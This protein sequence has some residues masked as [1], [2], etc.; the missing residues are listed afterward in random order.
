VYIATHGRLLVDSVA[1]YFIAVNV[2]V[3]DIAVNCSSQ[4]ST[5]E[6]LAEI[7]REDVNDACCN[8]GAQ[9]SGQVRLEYANTRDKDQTSDV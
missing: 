7:D 4:G 9:R 1:T 5:H 2:Y 6:R 8:D 3:G